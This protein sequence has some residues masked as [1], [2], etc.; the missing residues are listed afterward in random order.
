MHTRYSGGAY[1]AARPGTDG[2]LHQRSAIRRVRQLRLHPTSERRP[3]FARVVG[4][5]GRGSHQRN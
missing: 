1:S 3:T 5:G 4:T 2:K